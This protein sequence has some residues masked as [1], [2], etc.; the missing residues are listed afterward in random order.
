M[1]TSNVHRFAVALFFPLLCSISILAQEKFKPT[2]TNMT[3]FGGLF[4]RVAYNNGAGEAYKNRLNF[5]LQTFNGLQI[6]PMWAVGLTTGIDWYTSALIMPVAVGTRLD[7]ASS[8]KSVVVFGLLDAGYGFNW[9]QADATGYK[10]LGGMMLN[11][12]LGMKMYLKNRSA[13]T[14]SL[15]YKLQNVFVQKPTFWGEIEKYENRTYN[16]MVFRL[17]ISF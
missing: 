2:Y 10:T 7:F 3:E 11:S 4:G 12:G 14:M 6:K 16:R 17:G 8:P 5:T 13:F 15:S 9:L 1:I